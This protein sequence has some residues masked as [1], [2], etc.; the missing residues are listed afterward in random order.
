VGRD[1]GGYKSD[2][3]AQRTEIFL[4]RGLDSHLASQPVGQITLHLIASEATQSI[5]PQKE[6]MDCFVATL[7]CA[8][9]LRLSQ[10]MTYSNYNMDMPCGPSGLPLMQQR[11]GLRYFLGR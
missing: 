3:G 11:I 6:R 2:L 8:N 7:P 10:A 5:A 4:L 9:A 1:G